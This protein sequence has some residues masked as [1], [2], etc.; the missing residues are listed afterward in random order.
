MCFGRASLTVTRFGEK[1]AVVLLP[2]FAALRRRQAGGYRE[3]GRT[4][5]LAR[6]E[7]RASRNR[8]RVREFALAAR[9]TRSDLRELDDHRLLGLVREGIRDGRLIAMRAVADQQPALSETTRRR[10]L[11]R[12]IEARTR[13][14]LTHEGRRYQLVAD[15]DVAGMPDRD[16]YEVVR[17]DTASQVLDALAVEPG[18]P[19]DLASLFSQA[20]DQLT[21]DWRPP[22]SGPD[23]LVMLRRI[24]AARP[25]AAH[26]EPAITPSQLKA[27]A[28]AG[29]IEIEF[30][31]S[32]GQ[33]VGTVCRLE[34]PDC[35]LVEAASDGQGLVARRD[36]APGLCR[37]SL[38]DLDAERWHLET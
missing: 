3:V 26:R 30:V 6:I 11:V 37:L 12:E 38:P 29:W 17:R 14:R 10:R 16:Y 18:V 9:L 33:P 13:G 19:P 15:S 34:L 2:A 36:F 24:R 7:E 21:R 5:A 25:V 31:D 27:L 8:T 23:G 35:T 1:D 20:R 28:A 32:L 22:V 4:E